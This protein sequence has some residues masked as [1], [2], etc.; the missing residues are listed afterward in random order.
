MKEE[1]LDELEDLKDGQPD[2]ATIQRLMEMHTKVSEYYQAVQ[3]AFKSK[4]VASTAT[5]LKEE[6]AVEP[7]PSPAPS[8]VP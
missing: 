4:E 3:E 2:D 1:I 8:S 5:P 6:A 7:P